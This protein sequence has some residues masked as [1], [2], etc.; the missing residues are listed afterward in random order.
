MEQRN[1]FLEMDGLA[2]ETDTH[3]WFHD[4]LITDI[5]HE[6]N[7]FPHLYGMIVRNKSNAQYS[8]VILDNE[9]SEIIYENPSF[10]AMATHCEMMK[11]V[12]NK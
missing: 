7:T 8:R 6:D 9:K 5:L 3:E 1:K 11:L 4:K 2:A 10:E 12:K